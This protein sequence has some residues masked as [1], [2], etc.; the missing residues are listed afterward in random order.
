MTDVIRVEDVFV[1]KAFSSL[2]SIYNKTLEKDLK[3]E[4]VFQLK[5]I[6]QYASFLSKT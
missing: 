3:T 2:S 1:G 6:K 5:S 4:I